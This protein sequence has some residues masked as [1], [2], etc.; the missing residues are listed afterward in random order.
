MRKLLLGLFL[1]ASFNLQA[2]YDEYANNVVISTATLGFSSAQLK[3][4]VEE[5]FSTYGWSI[6][7]QSETT[8]KGDLKGG[9]SS[10]VEVN[11]SNP[12]AIKIQYLT[13]HDSE[14]YKF[15]KRL[16]NIRARMMVYLTDCTNKDMQ[17]TN[18]T[19]KSDVALRRNLMYAFYKYNWIIKS[20]SETE[21]TAALAA[22]G[23]LE[24]KI[25]ESG[26]VSIRRW[27]EVE[28]AWTDPDRDNY[29]RR[30]SNVL[31]QQ[32]MRCSK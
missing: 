26:K 22:R 15:Y 8:M 18:T 9:G 10:V 31:N 3:K 32:Q 29:V 28:E 2:A 25:N 5:A 27:D 21:I 1:F 20:I 17:Q 30:V 14:N 6:V 4:G 16:L 23:R 13:E 12:A 7:G 11:F 24:A 19:V